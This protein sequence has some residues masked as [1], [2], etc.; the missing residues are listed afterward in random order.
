[1][2]YLEPREFIMKASEDEIKDF[3]RE[4]LSRELN[5]K[6]GSHLRNKDVKELLKSEHLRFDMSG[7]GAGD[8]DCYFNN[9][10]ILK[11]F[12]DCGIWDFVS[13]LYLDAYK[14]TMTLYWGWWENSVPR[15]SPTLLANNTTEDKYQCWTTTEI[16]YD[17]ILK[18]SIEPREQEWNTR[19]FI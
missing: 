9:F 15:N 11:L 16:I 18:L 8:N 17:I 19:R 6:L 2:S 3:I 12:S 5:R 4:R 7:Y 10:E 1:M 14:G 13:Y